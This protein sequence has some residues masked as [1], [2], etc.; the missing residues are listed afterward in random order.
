MRREREMTLK[1]EASEAARR[2]NT[3]SDAQAAEL[4]SKLQLCMSERDA[5]QLRLEEATQASGVFP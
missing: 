5:L 1:A 3:L 2:A 4:E